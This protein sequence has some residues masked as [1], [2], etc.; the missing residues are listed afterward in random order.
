MQNQSDLLSVDTVI[1]KSQDKGSQILIEDDK[2]DYYSFFKAKQDGSPSAAFSS[3]Q[4]FAVGQPV[5]V[6]YRLVPYKGKN[7]RS[8]VK[9]RAIDSSRPSQVHRPSV[10]TIPQSHNSLML[11]WYQKTNPAVWSAIA[12]KIKVAYDQANPPVIP[13]SGD[14]INVEDIPF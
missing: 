5:T 4:Q 12:A 7:L 3:F 10:E 9:F 14:E 11:E 6:V 2:R 13:T 8:V 1:T